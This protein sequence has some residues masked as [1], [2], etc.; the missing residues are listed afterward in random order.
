MSWDVY[1]QDF[2][3][4][5]TFEEIPNDFAPGPIGKRSEII[6]KILA[7]VPF[8]E[9]SDPE[10]LVIDADEFSIEINMS[11]EEVLDAITFH[12]RGGG[13]AG[14]CVA[15]ILKSLGLRAHDSGTGDF[16]NMDAPD[17]GFAK[18]RELRDRL[19]AEPNTN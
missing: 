8:A 4:Y 3:P 12:I 2:G 6:E 18:W 1:A 17:E 5:K 7:I 16:F 11:D 9:F 14:E 13:D 19:R 15:S 10:W